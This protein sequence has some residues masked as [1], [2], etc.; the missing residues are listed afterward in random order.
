MPT[1][2]VRAGRNVAAILAALRDGGTFVSESPRGPQLYLDP[3][4][5]RAGR[6]S[7]EVRD[8]AGATLQVLSDSGTTAA[9]PVVG[10]LWDRTFDVPAAARYVRAQLVSSTGEVRALSNPVWADRL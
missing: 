4:R 6:V 10:M 3:D 7:V 9:A 2:W 8:G 1:T 5:G